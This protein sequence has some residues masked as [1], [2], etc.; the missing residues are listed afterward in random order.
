MKVWKFSENPDDRRFT[1][2]TFSAVQIDTQAVLNIFKKYS[3]GQ[4]Q[5]HNCCHLQYNFSIFVKSIFGHGRLTVVFTDQ[6]Y[7]RQM[8]HFFENGGEKVK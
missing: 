7:T 4:K 6:Q 3:K 1:M 2:I 5:K 8:W